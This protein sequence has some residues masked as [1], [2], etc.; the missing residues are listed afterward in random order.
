MALVSY[1]LDQAYPSIGGAQM[2]LFDYSRRRRRRSSGQALVE[3]SLIIPIFMLLIVAIAEFS[4][5]LTIKTGVGFAGLDATQLAAQL[6]N[7]PE[8]DVMILQLIEKDLQPPVDR[9]NVQSVIIFWTDPNGTVKASDT[10]TKP[11]TYYSPLL[12]VT[13]PYSKGAQGYPPTNRCNILSAVG[14]SPHT[15]LDWIGVTINYQYAWVTPLPGMA[16]LS[17][18]A[19]LFSEKHIS[20]IEP[21]Q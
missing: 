12:N 3:F 4:F 20:R 2:R 15:S 17:S 1:A 6:G 19:P 21:V 14:C 13:I 10:W 7:T 16:Q 18:S 5:L 8:A 11:G 9:T